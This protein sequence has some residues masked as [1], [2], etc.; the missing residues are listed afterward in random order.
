MDLQQVINSSWGL[1]LAM[2]LARTAPPGVGYKIAGWVADIMS[3]RRGAPVVRA[4]RLNQWMAHGQNLEGRA[5]DAA[6]RATFQ[7]S[8]RAIFDLHHYID[9]MPA[10]QRLVDLEPPV[11]DFVARKEFES[12]GLVAVGLHMSNFDLVL[13]WMC[14]QGLKPLVLTIPAPAGGRRL[15]YEARLKTGMNLVPTSVSALRQ[16][17]KHL[18][19]GGL[20]V[21]GIDRAIENPPVCPR[22]FGSPAALPVHHIYL[23]QKAHVPVQIFATTLQPDGRYRVFCSD[24]IEMDEHLDRDIE[25][26]RNAEK[27]LN[28]AESMIQKAPEQWLVP[29][30]VWPDRMDLVP[31]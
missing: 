21:T 11:R 5:L 20:V 17:V 14:K 2:W 3:S 9:D 4:I 29:L 16:A 24:L 26:L 1:K 18:Q 19:Q 6:V 10:T 7:H 31:S 15:E 8:A 13:Q 22:F 30:P 23:A 12:R 28:I 25:T 27:V